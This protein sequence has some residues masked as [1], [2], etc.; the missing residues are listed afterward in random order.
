M[1]HVCILTWIINV[2][3]CPRSW[4]KPSLPGKNS[5]LFGFFKSRG[6]CDLQTASLTADSAAATSPACSRRT[7]WSSRSS[8]SVT[9]RSKLSFLPAHT[10][11]DYSAV[12]DGTSVTPEIKNNSRVPCTWSGAGTIWVQKEKVKGHPDLVSSCFILHLDFTCL[13][14]K[15]LRVQLQNLTAAR[16]QTRIKPVL[17]VY[18]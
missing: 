16:E 2:T 3:I 1:L 5:V 14:K 11:P 17:L 6:V 4:R 7:D 8:A 15:E 12:V 13:H 18:F 10:N 9:Q